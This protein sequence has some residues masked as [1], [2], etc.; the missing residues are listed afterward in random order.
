MRMGRPGTSSKV[1]VTVIALAKPSSRRTVFKDG[2][3]S[4]PTDASH[5][6]RRAAVAKWTRPI[7]LGSAFMMRPRF[8]LSIQKSSDPFWMRAGRLAFALLSPAAAGVSK[9]S[10]QPF[11]PNVTRTTPLLI[12][13]LA[14]A[15][16]QIA[17]ATLA[18]CHRSA[19]SAT[20]SSREAGGRETCSRTTGRPSSVPRVMGMVGAALAVR[21]RSGVPAGRPSLA[22]RSASSRVMAVA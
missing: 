6:S 22:H 9:A 10:S 1:S 8:W 3:P 11:L 21:T 12:M 20:R 18:S 15:G 13:P 4:G 2:R 5:F 7:S 14:V 17:S 19:R 16:S